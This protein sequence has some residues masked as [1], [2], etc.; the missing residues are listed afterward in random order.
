MNDSMPEH[1]SILFPCAQQT[2]FK[3]SQTKVLAII[4]KCF[5]QEGSECFYGYYELKKDSA[6]GYLTII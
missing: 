2:N 6:K 4:F 3:Q 1:L 5:E